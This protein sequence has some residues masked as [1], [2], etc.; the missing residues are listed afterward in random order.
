[1]ERFEN[2]ENM[3]AQSIGVTE[4]WRIERTE[5]DEVKREVHVYVSAQKTAAYP[6]PECGEM[7]ARYDEEE[8]ERIWRHGAVV[9]FPCYVHC[10]RPR[11]KCKK[12]GKLHVVRAPWAR[13][14]SRDS[15]L[16]ES[17]AMLLVK[18]MPVE[19]A[20]KLLRVSHTSATG[21]LRYWVFKA[22]REDDLS[23]VRAICIDETS[24]KRGQSYVTVV[25]DAIARRVI[26]ADEGRRADNVEAFSNELVEKGG[27]CENIRQVACDMSGAYMSGVDLCFPKAAL[28]IDKFYVK[29]LMLKALDEVRREEQG[30]QR[31]RRRDAGKKLLMIPET[32]MTEQ[33]SEKLQ[34]LSKE[35]P[36]TGRAFRMV[37][38]LDTM[39]ACK[40]YEDGKNTFDKLIN[41]LRR[42]RLQPM[43]NVANTLKK[44][45]QQ[46]L[47]YFFH[48]LTN[49]IAEGINSMIQSAKR[50]A[51]GFRTIEGYVAAIFLAVG[52]LKLDCPKLFA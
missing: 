4:P 5:F 43:K 22:V 20:R 50:R 2:Y 32:R 6:C 36:K 51:R 42:S 47:S 14:N 12:C 44:Y 40:D 26:Y 23:K 3:F 27:D 9:F 19:N 48:R 28:T 10:R 34:A 41:W 17:Y 49:A 29:Q 30:K 52:K 35:F 1:M 8:T 13:P 39:Y 45:R 24:F 11:I 31:S 21:I 7:S 25:S 37:Q 15:L 33:Q 16:F 18:F 46:I 38:G